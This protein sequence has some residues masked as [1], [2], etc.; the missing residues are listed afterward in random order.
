MTLFE[1]WGCRRELKKQMFAL[2]DLIFLFKKEKIYTLVKYI[3]GI[4]GS[5]LLWRK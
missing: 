5:S 1:C 4:I 2:I 3:K